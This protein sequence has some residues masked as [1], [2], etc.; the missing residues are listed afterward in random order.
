MS[1]DFTFF[2]GG[3]FSQWFNSPFTIEDIKF[4][5]AEQWMMACKA[6]LFRDNETLK[7]I[8]EETDPSKQKSLG[9]QVKDFK[10]E[11]L[12]ESCI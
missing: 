3:P 10:K 4:N 2:W 6:R 7:R 8:M 1:K 12:L 11:V 9:K 5:T